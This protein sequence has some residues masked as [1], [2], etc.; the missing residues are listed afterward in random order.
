VNIRFYWTVIFE[1]SFGRHAVGNL[2]IVTYSN[3]WYHEYHPDRTLMPWSGRFNRN[4]SSD[5]RFE[6]CGQIDGRTRTDMTSPIC[7]HFMYRTHVCVQR[8][9]QINNECYFSFSTV[10]LFTHK[11]LYTIILIC[12]SDSIIRICTCVHENAT[13]NCLECSIIHF[14]QQNTLSPDV[15]MAT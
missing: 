13:I 15:T 1:I 11:Y 14:L 8:T 2:S 5:S 9:H 6:S 4:P 12:I 7:V 3:C 10:I